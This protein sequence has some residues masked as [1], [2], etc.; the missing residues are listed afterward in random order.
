LQIFWL[1]V[2]ILAAL[3]GALVGWLITGFLVR[4]LV[5]L[6]FHRPTPRPV[7]ALLRLGGAIVVGLLVFYY[8]HPGGSG[9]WGL[10]GGGFGLGGGGGQGQAGTGRD[11][12]ST[13]RASTQKTDVGKGPTATVAPDTLPIEMIGGDRYKKAGGEGRYYL[14][15]GKE[16]ART[17]EEVKELLQK[18]KGRYRKVEILIYPDSVASPHHA[19][20]QLEALAERMGLSRSITKLGHR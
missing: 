1:V 20:S 19:I 13:A 4:L 2:R 17:L 16:P 15:G 3:A 7:L 11:S 8:L 14:I 5:R 10:G 18:N 9:G 6:A 12:G